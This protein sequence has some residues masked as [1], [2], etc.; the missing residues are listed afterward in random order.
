MMIWGS[1]SL[2]IMTKEEEH[3]FIREDFEIIEQE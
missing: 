2:T 3:V 1:L